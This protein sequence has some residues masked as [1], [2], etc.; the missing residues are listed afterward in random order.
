[1]YQV[2]L[3]FKI[4]SGDRKTTLEQYTNPLL[5]CCFTVRVIVK[6]KCTEREGECRVQIFPYRSITP[7]T[8]ACTLKRGAA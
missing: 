7:L 3:T 1:M 5:L 2:T 8:S 6:A 4:I